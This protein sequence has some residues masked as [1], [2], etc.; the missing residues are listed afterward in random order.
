MRAILFVSGTALLIAVGGLLVW[1]PAAALALAVLVLAIDAWRIRRSRRVAAAKPAPNIPVR[2][3]VEPPPPVQPYVELLGRT[4]GAG[5]SIEA[6]RSPS[7]WFVAVSGGVRVALRPAPIGPR[8]VAE[9]IVEAMAA[10]VRERA[11]YAAI[12][13]EYRPAPEVT[14]LA[15]EGRVHIVNLA[16]LEAYLA[17][18]VSFKP[19]LPHPVTERRVSA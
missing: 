15:K 11:Q 6:A 17:L 16:R 12:M 4:R 18:A 9:D 14:D 13:C 19:S 7:P 10:K 3:A 2:V 1:R 8:A 5:W